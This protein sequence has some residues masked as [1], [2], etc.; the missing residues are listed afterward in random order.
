MTKATRNWLTGW[1]IVV[2]LVLAI[3]TLFFSWFLL[4]AYSWYSEER[5]QLYVVTAGEDCVLLWRRLG[6]FLAG[7]LTLGYT[8]FLFNRWADPYFLRLRVKY[9]AMPENDVRH[10]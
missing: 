8:W 5:W 1:G 4:N 9:A 7:F 10:S 6:L 2:C 3:P